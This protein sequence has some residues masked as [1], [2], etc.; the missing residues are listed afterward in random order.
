MSALVIFST[1]GSL[2]GIILTGPRV[3]FSMARD[4]LLFHWAGHLHP[5]FRTPHYAIV[6]QAVWSAVL[7]LTG[8]YRSLFTRAVFTEWIFFGLMALGIFI[9]RKRKVAGA[10]KMWGY[11]FV[12]AIFIF[13][14]FAIAVNQILSDPVDSIAGLGLVFAGVPVYYLW[15][16]RRIKEES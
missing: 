9:L 2:N 7:V 10:Y 15:A 3:Y 1:F 11:P 4:G 8:T 14:S 5:R 16:R 12:T 13:S 6:M